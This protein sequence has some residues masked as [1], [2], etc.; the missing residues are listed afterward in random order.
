MR[1]ARHIAATVRR[2]DHARGFTLIELVVTLMVAGVLIAVAV[3][4]FAATI[5]QNRLVSDAN[6]FLTMFNLARSE[7][8]KRG[9]AVSVEAVAGNS[10]NEWGGGWEIR[11]QEAG[12]VRTLR[13]FPALDT[14]TSLDSVQGLTRFEFQSTGR[15]GVTDTLRL[16]DDR[17]GETGR[18]FSVITTG[19]VRV[20]PVTC[21]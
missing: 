19:Q 7:A 16:C 20:A 2:T 11:T 3:P 9:V 4:G 15:T 10:S 6:Q 18:E 1:P 13:R 17:V 5:R 8:I 12:A 14:R 21:T